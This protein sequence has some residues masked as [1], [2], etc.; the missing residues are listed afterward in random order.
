MRFGLAALRSTVEQNPTGP[1]LYW[2]RAQAKGGWTNAGQEKYHEVGN[3]PH[4][5]F[6][7]KPA[8]SLEDA[9]LKPPVERP[10]QQ[11]ETR[12]HCS[13][14]END[15]HEQSQPACGLPEN[16]LLAQPPI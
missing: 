2:T 10:I 12:R 14:G 15:L 9:L 13:I 1:L 11:D 16:T 8:G 5:H 7:A 6:E 3:D 4:N